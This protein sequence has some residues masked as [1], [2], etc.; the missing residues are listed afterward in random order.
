MT[1][2]TGTATIRIQSAEEIAS[3][4][5]NQSPF[6]VWPE[7]GS[8]FAERSMRLRQ[9]ASG[10]AMG[11]FLAFVSALA[12]AQQAALQG[13]TDV[14]LPDAADIDRAASAGVP[15]LPA[16]DWPRAAAW[17]NVARTCAHALLSQA[18]DAAR[19]ALAAMAV[20]SD[21]WL[22]RQA[23]CLL[24]GVMQGLELA[25]SAVVAAA[26]QVY[27]TH[28]V[29]ATRARHVARGDPF[30]RIDDALQCPCCGGAPV[31]G[32]TRFSGGATGQR[33]LVCGLCA[34]QWHLPRGRCAHC[35]SD[36]HVAYQSLALADDAT[37]GEGAAKAAV[38]AETC[39]ECGHYFK[40]MHTD[41]DP[42][43]EP[44]ADD[45]ASLTLDLLMAE[46][47]KQRHGVNLMLLFGAPG[48]G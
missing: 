27:W 21:D 41:R 46:Q 11:D 10:H 43:I 23:D 34:A 29:L 6:L 36:R 30:G 14:P 24:T 3:Q 32:L 17:R 42:M 39:D 35:G 15:L 40:L 44:V 13:F 9:L 18:P 26:L 25:T 20:A 38:Q 33:Y 4:A 5:G 7:R 31:V 12:Q 2:M 37:G 47:G 48:G 8:V 16:A 22:E 1:G 45:L 28:L 19:P